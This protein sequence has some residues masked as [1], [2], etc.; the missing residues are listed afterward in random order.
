MGNVKLNILKFIVFCVLAQSTAPGKPEPLII[1]Y[2]D[3][4]N[5]KKAMEYDLTMNNM[6]FLKPGGSFDKELYDSYVKK[7]DCKLAEKYYLAYLEDVNEPFQRARVYSKLGALYIGRVSRDVTPLDEIDKEK[8]LQYYRK[9]LAE[10]PEAISVASINTRA[11]LAVLPDPYEAFNAQKE[12]YEWV[13]S[14]NKQKII[15]NWLPLRPGN[16]K[17]SEFAVDHLLGIVDILKESEARNIAE[18][19]FTLGRIAMQREGGDGLQ[20]DPRYLLEIIE[21][22]PGTKASE[23]AKKHVDTLPDKVIDEHL[24]SSFLHATELTASDK[25]T[26]SMIAQHLRANREVLNSFECEYVRSRENTTFGIQFMKEQVKSRNPDIIIDMPEKMVSKGHFAFKDDKV[27]TRENTEGA[28]DYYHYVKNG[29]QLRTVSQHNPRTFVLGTEGNSNIGPPIPDPWAYTGHPFIYKLDKLE[30]RNGEVISVDSKFERDRELKVVKIEQR[31]EESIFIAL[32]IDFSVQDGYLPVRV[33]QEITTKSGEEPEYISD[34]TTSKILKYDF[35]DKS[36]FLPVSYNQKV[37]RNGKLSSTSDFNIKAETVK[38]NP[39]LPD[40]MFWVDIQPGDMVVDKDK[41][42][43][44][45]V[46]AAGVVGAPA[47][48]FTLELLG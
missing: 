17:P 3:N 12:Y 37:Y 36:L 9:A 13:L 22:F 2:D 24:D 42:I 25:E 43:Q 28:D 29:K 40:D 4:P 46:P 45:R 21:K 32:A 44:Y 18:R 31:P 19:A 34:A 27:L 15:D 48:D 35:D 11:G 8:A 47:P 20:F 1:N 30:K 5:L 23:Y 10:A 14:I 26:L 38:I 39:D 33:R 6:I 16:V 7:A 41:G